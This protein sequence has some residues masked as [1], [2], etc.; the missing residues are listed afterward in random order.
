MSEKTLDTWVSSVRETMSFIEATYDVSQPDG[1]GQH[2]RFS[3]CRI[4]L[5]KFADRSIPLINESGRS[6]SREMNVVSRAIYDALAFGNSTI[7]LDLS[8]GQSRVSNPLTGFACVGAFGDVEYQ[9]EFT[10]SGK[11]VSMK[12]LNGVGLVETEKD[13]WEEAGV[14]TF[15][16]F[17]RESSRS[18]VGESVI[19][20]GARELT[21]AATVERSRLSSVSRAYS[22]PTFV[23]NGIWQAMAAEVSEDILN[24][25]TKL[26]Q[27]RATAL[28]L[29]ANPE[30]GSKLDLT[31]LDPQSFAPYLTVIEF[32]AKQTAA[33]FNI[34]VGELGI[35]ESNPSS[36]DAL[37]ALK[38]D[39]V[40]SVNAF[41]K[42]ITPTLDDYIAAVAAYRGEK[43]PEITF[44]DPAT[45]SL[46]TMAD[47]FVK[48]A[49][50]VPHL[51]YSP[52]AL[53]RAG[54]PESA[55]REV[56]FSM[57]PDVEVSVEEATDVSE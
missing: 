35:T 53:R 20:Q 16:I 9:E 29:P 33:A 45:P 44:E 26:S 51:A 7:I 5:E 52:E 42:S 24:Q 21:C 39:L 1:L 49:S 27:N 19:T 15:S 54:V 32:Y 43:A 47:A 28:Y 13:T 36:A 12:S 31:K 30:D 6:Y 50:V 38:E 55:I 25:T 18:P 22:R 56:A 10:V 40:I 48:V 41:N 4:G 23:L 57:E 8:T 14:L 3:W 11:K 37:Y 46:V 34:Q 17:H 2:S